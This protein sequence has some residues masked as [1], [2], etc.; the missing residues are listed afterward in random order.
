MRSSRIQS[1]ICLAFLA[2]FLLGPVILI[3]SDGMTDYKA[4][5]VTVLPSDQELPAGFGWKVNWQVNEGTEGPYGFARVERSW[6][7]VRPLQ[8]GHSRQNFEDVFSVRCSL[9]YTAY[10][11]SDRRFEDMVAN[12][13]ATLARAGYEPFA[14][15]PIAMVRNYAAPS[16]SR[17]VCYISFWK[18]IRTRCEVSVCHD[19]SG[20]R[21]TKP[22]M[23]SRWAEAQGFC[24][25]ECERLAS[26]IF[27]RLGKEKKNY[28]LIIVVHGVGH[29]DKGWSESLKNAWHIPAEALQPGSDAWVEVTYDPSKP[30]QQT[31]EMLFSDEWVFYVS[32]RLKEALERARR[33]DRKV[34]LVAHS[35]G[36]VMTKLAMDGGSISIK[37]TNPSPG[38]ETSDVR[39]IIPRLNG[40]IDSWITLA[41]PLGRGGSNQ[42]IS[43]DYGVP[44]F[45][46]PLA[47][48]AQVKGE[49]A[50]FYDIRD[51]VSEGAEN[52]SGSANTNR[53]VSGLTANARNPSPPPKQSKTG[54][55]KVPNAADGGD[56]NKGK[57][58]GLGNTINKA[59]KEMGD[60]YDAYGNTPQVHTAIWTNPEVVSYIEKTFKSLTKGMPSP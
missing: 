33:E 12:Q 56:K 42:Y 45:S 41:S 18:D 5:L 14:K 37:N 32:D 7:A 58:W 30:H 8:G 40:Q 20:D 11:P 36:T 54:K 60:S 21:D 3:A 38:Q 31:L 10:I 4:R 50:N 44:I 48:P 51:K 9:Y 47:K 24:Q 35:W 34:I 57:F 1:C 26:L 19:L 29:H 15:L 13:Q 17:Y 6:R 28:P 59:K 25:R 22:D 53:D 52:L 49:W 2:A 27:N 39:R 55:G 46:L 23:E 43:R 16:R